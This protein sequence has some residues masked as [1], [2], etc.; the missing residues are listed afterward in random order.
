MASLD[1]KGQVVTPVRL[2][3]SISKIAIGYAI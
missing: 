2:V 3:P 1:L